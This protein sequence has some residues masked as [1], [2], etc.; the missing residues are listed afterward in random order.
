MPPLISN[1]RSRWAE[2]AFTIIAA[3]CLAV[4]AWAVLAPDA[5][6]DAKRKPATV[7]EA[8]AGP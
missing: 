1:S 7:Q 5:A 2:V 4:L 6:S 8:V 3:A